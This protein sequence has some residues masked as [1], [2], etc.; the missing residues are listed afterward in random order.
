MVK[1]KVVSLY[2]LEL[3][4]IFVYF[5]EYFRIIFLLNLLNILNHT[6]YDL[7]ILKRVAL[8]CRF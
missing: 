1:L 5:E 3:Q 2:F 4:Q 7:Q 6:L 8:Q